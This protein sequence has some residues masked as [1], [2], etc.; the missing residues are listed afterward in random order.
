MVTNSTARPLNG[1]HGLVLIS[2]LP[3]RF[4]PARGV[5]LGERRSFVR[6]LISL[7]ARLPGFGRL[8]CI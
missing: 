4:S 6:E 1:A 3:V 7:T 8:K 5:T 2:M